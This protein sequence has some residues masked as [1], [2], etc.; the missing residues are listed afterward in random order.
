MTAAQAAIIAA[1]ITGVG[2]LV[3]VL[4]QFSLA[5]LRLELDGKLQ[6][7]RGEIEKDLK[8][9]EVRLRVAAEFRLKLM[10]HMLTDVADFRAKLG[11]AAGSI[12]LLAHEVEPRGGG[13]ERARELLREAQQAHV[14]LAGAGP[15]MP[16]EL[17][18]RASSLAQEFHE[19]LS[20]VV[21]WANLPSREER[22]ARCIKTSEAM[23]EIDA[24]T[25]ALFN[26]WQQNE[27]ARFAGHLAELEGPSEDSPT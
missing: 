17:R 14:A 8:L 23:G 27:F 13:S 25:K 10:D 6:Q 21:S 24:R 16:P 19:A 9:H 20:D 18:A 2:T 26:A 7:M 5:R 22:S 3:A 4:V 1:V 11:K 15:Y 12:I